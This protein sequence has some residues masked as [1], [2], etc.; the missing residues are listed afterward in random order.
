MA[1]EQ[2]QGSLK[3]RI[4]NYTQNTTLKYHRGQKSP[5]LKP[6]LPPDSSDSCQISSNADLLGSQIIEQLLVYEAESFTLA[7][8]MSIPLEEDDFR[9]V[10]HLELS[11]DK[12]HLC[13]LDRTFSRMKSQDD[14]PNF[15]KTTSSRAEFS[16]KKKVLLELS[17]GPYNVTADVFLELGYVD[18][19]LE[20][21]ESFIYD[22]QNL[23]PSRCGIL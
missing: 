3:L 2:N 12:T 14:P 16:S 13:N 10:L 1:E 8:F 22:L 19:E 9:T 4:S 5:Q 20:E 17:A 11:L 6:W 7:I 15:N 21:R 18:I 23:K